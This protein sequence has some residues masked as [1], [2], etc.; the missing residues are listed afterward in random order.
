MIAVD[1]LQG[2]EQW[3]EIRRGKPTAS[4]FEKILTPKTLKLSKQSVAYQLE[5]IAQ[6]LPGY[7][8]ALPTFDMQRGTELEPEA[9]AK[10]EFLNDIDVDRIG[11]VYGNDQRTWGGSPDGLVGS[12]G[13]LETK[14]PKA[15]THLEYMLKPE[16]PAKYLPQVWGC[17]LITG[18]EWWDWMSFHPELT[19]VIVRVERDEQ[20]EKWRDAFLPAI[21]TFLEQLNELKAK[22]T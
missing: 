20:F 12:D 22:L 9:I 1:C 16:V 6:T 4:C 14:C 21:E 8:P 10:Y 13:G 2:S 5:L 3:D 18:R 17:L 19:P 7:A 15:S 11:F